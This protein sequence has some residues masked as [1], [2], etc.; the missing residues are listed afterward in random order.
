MDH[1]ELKYEGLNTGDFEFNQ[2]IQKAV[3]AAG[4]ISF[5]FV[6]FKYIGSFFSKKNKQNFLRNVE[7]V[8]IQS[9]ARGFLVRNQISKKRAAVLKIDNWLKKRIDLKKESEKKLEFNQSLIEDLKAY[10]ALSLQLS[11]HERNDSEDL[12]PRA[13]SESLKADTRKEGMNP[14]SNGEIELTE[15]PFKNRQVRILQE[16]RA[17]LKRS[18]L[19]RM[20]GVDFSNLSEE[21]DSLCLDLVRLKSPRIL[22]VAKEDSFHQT[23]SIGPLESTVVGPPIS[24]KKKTH[25]DEFIDTI[26]THLHKDLGEVFFSLLSLRDSDPVTDFNFNPRTNEISL[27]LDRTMKVFVP[28]EGEDRT[29]NG[30]VLIFGPKVRMQMDRTLNKLHFLEGFI[31]ESEVKIGFIWITVN[32]VFYDMTYISKDHVELRAGMLGQSETKIRTLE[33][34]ISSWGDKSQIR[35]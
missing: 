9:L 13:F 35:P 28:K 17:I 27:N 16:R 19:A 34:L 1:I 4:I 14:F 24:A 20:P 32:P 29:K 30:S 22:D 8:K 6:M 12:R 5:V 23:S 15:S 3:F 25:R 7:V 26:S 11:N 18:I 10:Q 2:K 33:R 21:V 31:L